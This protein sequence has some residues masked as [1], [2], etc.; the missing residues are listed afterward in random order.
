M[1]SIDL[2]MISALRPGRPAAE[3]RRA[4]DSG[5]ALLRGMLDEIDY[6]L[7][8]V[9]A[10]GELRYANQLAHQELGSGGPLQTAGPLVRT[11]AEAEL[12]RLQ[13]ALA[14]AARGR[15]TL[16]TL[17]HNGHALLVAV[18]PMDAGE[19]G[20]EA[21]E[22]LALLV[23][24]KRASCAALTVDFYA[25]SNHLT[26]AESTVLLR[27]SQGLAPKEIARIH[28]V[29]LSTV[30]SQITSIRT[31][32]QTGSIGELAR[33]VAALPPFAPALKAAPSASLGPQDLAARGV[34]P[35]WPV[36]RRAA[37]PSLA[38]GAC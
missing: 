8:L 22:H 5:A 17:G 11:R 21:G 33:R 3:R 2:L 29:A 18:I 37:L 34:A 16:V 28:G 6:G 20:D 31:K 12:G 36:L 35:R 38:C 9:T 25:R 23:F 24:S 7:L 10:T 30:R 27:L 4:G 1:H 32:T 15:R 26:A 13:G 14:D 19:G